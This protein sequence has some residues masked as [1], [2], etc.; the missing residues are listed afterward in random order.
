MNERVSDW[1]C[2]CASGR[3]IEGEPI[4]EEVIQAVADNYDTAFYS[5]MIWPYHPRPE[6]GG[7]A[8]RETYVRN[9]GRVT[10]LKAERDGDVL[11]LFAKYA[12]NEFL[13][14]LNSMEQKLFSSVEIWL[15]FQ[16]KGYPYLG[17]VAATDIPAS[18]HT[19]IMQFSANDK[20]SGRL[21]GEFLEFSI[22]ELKTPGTPK[23]SILESLFSAVKK[24]EKKQLLTTHTE[25]QQQVDELKNMLSAVLEKLSAR[26][27]GNLVKTTDPTEQDIT[28]Q[29]SAEEIVILAEEVVL[30]AIEAAG[31]P[32]DKA[33][34]EEL[35][36]TQKQ[37]TE[38]IQAFSAND[39][40][41]ASRKRRVLSA[42]SA[43]RAAA[44]KAKPQENTEMLSLREDI[45]EMKKLLSTSTTT[46]PSGAP[47][48][49]DKKPVL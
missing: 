7:Y 34:A 41:F 10:E 28:I 17:G 8:A 40:H 4:T 23:K 42:F 13:L 49:G 46:K 39:P 27:G 3:S 33:I 5:A 35:A 18:T 48:T 29:L 37:L 43:D 15:D 47:G 45:A 11:K 1:I 31:N 6:N 12:P 24:P 36:T 2:I 25:E 32:E 21:R 26:E 38:K 14:Y 16:G 19:E 44:A 20:Q 30:L 9:L 22:G